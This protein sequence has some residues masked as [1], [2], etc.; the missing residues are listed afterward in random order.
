MVEDLLRRGDLLDNAVLHDHDTVAEGHGFGL[1]VS[2]IDERTLD[3][4][5]QLDELGTHL[6]T[7]LGV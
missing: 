2:N 4:V 7:K 1:V 6:V 3:L 5:A